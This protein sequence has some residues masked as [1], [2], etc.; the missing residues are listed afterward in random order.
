MR[1]REYRETD[2]AEWIRMRVA[3]WPETSEKADGAEHDAMQWLEREDAVV[4]VAERSSEGG[5]AGFAEV[6]ART[7]ADGCD[8]SPLGFLEGWYVDVDCRGRGV[9]R[10]LMEE[11]IAWCRGRGYREF[12]SDALL[13]NTIS[14]RA[15]ERVGFREVERAVRYRMALGDDQR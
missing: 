5:L 13:E 7:Y 3:L 1:V 14:H 4:I 9:G 6:G 8:S 2:W 11:A 15:H 10:A 12:A